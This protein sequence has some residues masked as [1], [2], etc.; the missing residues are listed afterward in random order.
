MGWFDWDVTDSVLPE[1][2]LVVV[3]TTT[4][5]LVRV[6]TDARCGGVTQPV[7]MPNGDTYLVSSAL[8]SAAHRVGRL[9][10]APCVLRIPADDDQLDRDYSVSLE[11]VTGNALA[12]EPVPSNDAV[13]LRA[14]DDS[15]ATIEGPMLTWEFTSQTAWRWLRW[16]P[17]TNESVPMP[18]IPPSTADVTWFQVDGHVYGSE[19][20]ADYSRTTLIELSADAGAV[21]SI[22]VPGFLHGVARI[23]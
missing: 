10:T 2:G 6:D 7:T 15:L 1:T 4:D 13:F 9:E 16:N 11:A 17:A 18:D 3:D 23:R 12:G 21:R 19:T 20:T 14:F 8:A 5:S 22:T